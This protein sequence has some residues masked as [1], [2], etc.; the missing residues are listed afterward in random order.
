MNQNLKKNFQT[1]DIYNMEKHV[2]L[3]V[4]NYIKLQYPKAIFRSDT[5]AGM[6]LT[7]GQ[8]KQQKAIQNGMAFPDLFIAEPRGV[9]H[10]LFLELKDHGI[11]L[12]KRDGITMVN[13]HIEEQ[14]LCLDALNDRGYAAVFA[15]GF[16][17]AAKIIRNY[18][19]L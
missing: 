7:I 11:K 16:D 1:K 15:V 2:Q 6:R 9:Y 13:K 18:M 8:S 10:G 3:A 17:E 12:F 5:G 19:K 14:Q 4:V